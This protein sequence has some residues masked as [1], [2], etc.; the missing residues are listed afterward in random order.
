MHLEQQISRV[1]DN[2]EEIKITLIRNTCSLEEHMR[3][4]KIIEE[5]VKAIKE[6]EANCP[7]KMLALRKTSSFEIIRDIGVMLG[8]VLIIM[9]ILGL[10]K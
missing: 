10:I 1:V 7:G 6:K 3:R 2:I 8:V 9:Q 4:T 5:E